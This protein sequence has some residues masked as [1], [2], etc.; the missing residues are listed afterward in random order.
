MGRIIPYIVENIMEQENDHLVVST[1][2]S[3]K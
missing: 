1:Y 3:E 2:P